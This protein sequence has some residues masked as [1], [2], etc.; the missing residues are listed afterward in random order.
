MEAHKTKDLDLAF[1]LYTYI[2]LLVD[3][4]SKLE[5]SGGKLVAVEAKVGLS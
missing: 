3:G 2:V 5:S 1:K 4:K